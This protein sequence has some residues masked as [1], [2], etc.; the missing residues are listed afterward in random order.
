MKILKL[1]AYK[2]LSPVLY[3]ESDVKTLE[4]FKPEK[5]TLGVSMHWHNRIEIIVAKSGSLRMF[6]KNRK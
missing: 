2:E 1:D 3:G 4:Y 5:D 6:I